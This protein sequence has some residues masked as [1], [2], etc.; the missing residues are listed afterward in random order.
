MKIAFIHP[1]FPGS[2]GTGATFSATKIIE[3]LRDYGHEI[4]AYCKERPEDHAVISGIE[5]RDISHNGINPHSRIGLNRN[6]RSIS[7]EFA[8]YD[9]V[10]S[11]LMSTEPALQTIREETGTPVVLTL[12]AYGGICPKN[13]LLHSSGER[14]RSRGISRCLSCFARTN[15]NHDFK[16]AITRSVYHTGN[17]GIIERSFRNETSI[18]AFHALSEHIKQTYSSFGY[19]NSRIHILPNIHDE[20]FEMPDVNT[21]NDRLLFVGYLHRHK[22]V[23]RLIPMFEEYISKYDDATELT[24]IGDGPLR[25]DLC[26]QIETS[27]VREQIDYQGQVPNEDLPAVYAEHDVFIYPGRWDE[28]FGR[29]FLE[30]L[31]SKTPVVAT[32]VGAAKEIIG[33]AGIVVDSADALSDAVSQVVAKRDQ[34]TE[35]SNEQIQRFRS[36]H[37]IPRFE[38][39]YKSVI[40]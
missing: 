31:A 33:N 39:L 27:S 36:P 35:S 14:C 25:E 23:D 24:I 8:N 9:V 34:Y 1:T 10:H 21:E 22:G 32:N 29:V 38:S 5:A 17:L 40:K 26:K 13:D 4:V 18:D 6:L 37:I 7:K 30:A 28:P 19:E 2:G 16:Q 15:K 3:G 20:R 11:Y 12:N